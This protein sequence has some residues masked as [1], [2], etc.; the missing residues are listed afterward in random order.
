MIPDRCC[1]T[2]GDERA[3][4]IGHVHGGPTGQ[5]MN[6]WNV[7]VQFFVSRGYAVLAPNIRGSSGYGKEYRDANLRDWGGKDLKDLVA[8]HRW[9]AESSVVDPTRIGV[10]GGS[11]GGF[12]TL[13]AM[14]KSPDVWAAG[15]SVVGM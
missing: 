13:I 1:R 6:G 5:T 2:R 7:Q 15:A 11:Y 9:L 3:P 14:T 8:G 4:A 12:M 10:T